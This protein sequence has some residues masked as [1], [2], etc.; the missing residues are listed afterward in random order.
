[1]KLY[2]RTLSDKIEEKF[3]TE[4]KHIQ[5]AAYLAFLEGKTYQEIVN[6]GNN[7]RI[8]L[9]EFIQLC[10]NLDLA[11]HLIANL[12]IEELNTYS[13]KD[14]II[15]KE[16]ILNCFL[17]R[18]Q[19][20]MIR[21][22]FD[23]VHNEN[24]RKK[25]IDN[26]TA[27]H[28]KQLSGYLLS[29]ILYLIGHNKTSQNG[30][31]ILMKKV[32]ERCP[33]EENEF[34]T[35]CNQRSRELAKVVSEN[36]N[37]FVSTYVCNLMDDEQCRC[38]NRE[39]QLHYYGDIQCFQANHRE[40]WN[41][42]KSYGIGFDFRNCFLVLSS[43]LRFSFE[44]QMPYP[45]MELDLFTICDLIYSRLQNFG[46][47]R[48]FFYTKDYH[49]L[50]ISILESVGTLLGEYLNNYE[51]YVKNPTEN[52]R[53]KVYFIFMK[54]KF[55]TI[56]K[57]LEKN[58][59]AGV[60]EPLVSQVYE[61]E[62]IISLEAMGRVGW[63][64]NHTGVVKAEEQPKFSD[65]MKLYDGSDGIYPKETIMQ[66]VIERVYIAQ[67][68]LP[69]KINGYDE[70]NKST[71][72]SILLLSELG[73]IAT[74]DYSPEYT[75]A[76]RSKFP[77]EQGELKKILILGALDGYANHGNLFNDLMV[78]VNS[79]MDSTSPLEYA[80]INLLICQEIVQLQMEYKYC[81]LYK[82]LEFDDERRQVFEE[83]FYEPKTDI[84]KKI[85]KQL[86]KENPRFSGILKYE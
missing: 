36:E 84:C 76:K 3:G 9:Y 60:I 41:I 44:R 2:E 73:K 78:L 83:E 14:D 27:K 77:K 33:K 80:N 66:A 49:T 59:L 47:D 19:S 31:N 46:V 51:V 20:I 29:T 53:I 40:T 10:N 26:F 34:F 50:G 72:I 71:I 86:I 30:E 16:S 7:K 64:I 52:K 65:Y 82:E 55:E 15:P 32:L 43:K 28:S 21:L 54:D 1:M 63:H 69:E 68:F 12:F 11:E 74:G 48:A 37:N 22:I 5:E 13:Y 67:M 79:I 45:L 38:F 23:N 58:N 18:D 85:R 39:Y 56:H 35:L 70:Y 57:Q 6:D 81:L 17:T 61:F 75:T 42:K 24:N 4:I 25:I 62:R 8:S